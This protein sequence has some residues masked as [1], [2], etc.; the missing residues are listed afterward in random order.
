M[1]CM[2]CKTMYAIREA[3]RVRRAVYASDAGDACDTG[4]TSDASDT[5]DESNAD[6]TH[7]ACNVHDAHYATDPND[8][9]NM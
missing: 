3:T 4:N 7:D 2:R 5:G 8:M 6:D 1:Q 9:C